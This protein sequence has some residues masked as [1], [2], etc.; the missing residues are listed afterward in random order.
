V[1]YPVS[2]LQYYP[3]TPARFSQR[4]VRADLQAQIVSDN[5]RNPNNKPSKFLAHDFKGKFARFGFSA[6]SATIDND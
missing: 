2:T 1:H 5:A 3:L 6:V 4:I